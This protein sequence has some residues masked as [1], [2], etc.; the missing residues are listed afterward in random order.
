MYALF[1][2]YY[3]S[4]FSSTFSNALCDN[5]L[6]ILTK[7]CQK[8]FFPETHSLCSWVFGVLE[9]CWA[10]RGGKNWIIRRKL[11]GDFALWYF[12]NTERLPYT[13]LL[14]KP[15]KSN[16]KFTSVSHP[17]RKFVSPKNNS[18]VLFKI[19]LIHVWGVSV[20]NY[21]RSTL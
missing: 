19:Q 8:N 4:Q 5:F 11:F 12:L 3:Y 20:N 1:L 13:I 15:L 10:Q 6:H 21:Q 2:S 7:M 9:K 17:Q 18:M 16:W 14:L